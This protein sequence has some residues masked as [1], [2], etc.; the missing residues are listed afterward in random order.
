MS[1]TR[2]TTTFDNV[3]APASEPIIPLADLLVGIAWLVGEGTKL[4]VKGG[5]LAYEGVRTLAHAAQQAPLPLQPLTLSQ[6]SPAIS[7]SKEARNALNALANR[8]DLQIPRAQAKA[9]K[10]RIEKLIVT[11]DKLG[12]DRMALELTEARQNRLQTTVLKLAS[13]TCR[14]IGFNTITLRAEQGLL[15]AKSNDGQRSLAVEVD[16]TGDEGVKLHFDA[17]GFHGG[18]CAQALDALQSG[19]RARGVRFDVRDRQRKDRRPAFDGRRIPTRVH[20]HTFN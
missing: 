19:L 12:I 5:V 14:E 6:A 15:I 7:E 17:E 2:D 9:L 10:S 4:A 3:E 8:T 1:E 18:T 16:K 13:E 20:A 11:N